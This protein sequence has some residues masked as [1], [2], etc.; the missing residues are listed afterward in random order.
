MK[1]ALLYILLAITIIL[2]TVFAVIELRTFFAGDYRLFNNTVTGGL[3]Y[4]SRGLYFL[5]IDAL[6]IYIILFNVNKK[7]ANIVLFSY[8]ACLFVGA[9]FSLLFYEYYVSLVFILLTAIL[10]TITSV[11]FFEKK[12]EV[13][14]DS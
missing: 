10:L 3:A 6:C 5:S 1:K 12:E 2:S 11:S 14:E 9:L 13:E 8:S 4:L 7:P